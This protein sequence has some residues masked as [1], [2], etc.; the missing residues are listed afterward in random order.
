[1]VAA[2]RTW[3][4]FL[5]IMVEAAVTMAVELDVLVE[6]TA[7]IKAVMVDHKEVTVDR[8]VD[9]EANKVD[10]VDPEALAVNKEDLVV[11][12]DLVDQEALAANKVDSAV[13]PVDSANRKSH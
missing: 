13:D 7:A 2:V 9:L 11:K 8:K 12:V 6:D 3:T 5:S 10:S 1:M 4:S